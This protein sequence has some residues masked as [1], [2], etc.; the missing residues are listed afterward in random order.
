VL[1]NFGIQ[2]NSVSKEVVWEVI[3][4][5]YVWFRQASSRSSAVELGDPAEVSTMLLGEFQI[6]RER[7]ES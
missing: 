4:F 1:F 6:G 3:R 2:V 5:V 7:A